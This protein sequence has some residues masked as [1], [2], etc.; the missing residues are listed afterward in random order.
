MIDDLTAHVLPLLSS[1]WDVVWL[2]LTSFAVVFAVQ[3][4]VTLLGIV[5]LLVYVTPHLNKAHHCLP[6]EMKKAGEG[7]VDML[8]LSFEFYSIYRALK[9]ESVKELP[10]REFAIF[11]LLRRAINE[12]RGAHLVELLDSCAARLIEHQRS[13]VMLTDTLLRDRAT[14]GALLRERSA[15]KC[16]RDHTISASNTLALVFSHLHKAQHPLAEL[17][18]EEMIQSIT[19]QKSSA[20]YIEA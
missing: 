5:Y 6:S 9:R 8:E 17:V 20:D 13:D 3:L 2:I 4:S 18:S 1:L 11:Y 10:L 14:V 19:Q 12:G 15:S 16:L 7:W